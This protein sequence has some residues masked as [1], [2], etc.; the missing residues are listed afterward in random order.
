[1]AN[2][3]TQTLAKKS[4]RFSVSR[5]K[6]FGGQDKKSAVGRSMMVGFL[7]N[8]ER[9]FGRGCGGVAQ[10]VNDFNAIGDGA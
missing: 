6:K 4:V 9:R 8:F 7:R 3:Q 10:Y 1:M 2:F 5:I